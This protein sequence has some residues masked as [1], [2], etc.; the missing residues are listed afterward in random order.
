MKAKAIVS[1]SLNEKLKYDESVNLVLGHH[2]ARIL[3]K[4]QIQ[5]FKKSEKNTGM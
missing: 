5:R 2:G 1:L 3:K 4:K